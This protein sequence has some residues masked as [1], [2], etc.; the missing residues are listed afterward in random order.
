MTSVQTIG[1]L[2]VFKTFPSAVD[3]EL[4]AEATEVMM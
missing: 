1:K 3:E 2:S 4:E